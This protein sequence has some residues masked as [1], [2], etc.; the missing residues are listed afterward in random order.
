MLSCNHLDIK[1][2][3]ANEISDMY[4]QEPIYKQLGNLAKIS[5]ETMSFPFE[6][7]NHPMNNY[8]SNELQSFHNAEVLL[9]HC[10]LFQGKPQLRDEDQ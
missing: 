5:P 2:K 1:T 4:L 8:Y 6:E 7:M 3:N 10:Q 9:S